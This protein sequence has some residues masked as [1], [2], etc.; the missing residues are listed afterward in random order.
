MPSFNS[1][2]HNAEGHKAMVGLGKVVSPDR[3][4]SAASANTPV[5]PAPKRQTVSATEA[6]VLAQAKQQKKAVKNKKK[7]EKRKAANALLAQFKAGGVVQ[8]AAGVNI[9]VNPGAVPAVPVY[10]SGAQRQIMGPTNNNVITDTRFQ[11]THSPQPTSTPN[12]SAPQQPVWFNNFDVQY[13]QELLQTQTT[14]VVSNV[15]TFA[16]IQNLA[17]TPTQRAV[18]RNGE[19]DMK[20]REKVPS[21]AELILTYIF[22]MAALGLPVNGE[23]PVVNPR[24]H[25]KIKQTNNPHVITPLVLLDTGAQVTC[26]RDTIFQ[27]LRIPNTEL[28]PVTTQVAAANGSLL[29][30]LGVIMLDIECFCY[31]ANCPGT[32]PISFHV[33]KGL[34]EQILLSN[35]H[36]QQLGLVTIRNDNEKLF[37]APQSEHPGSFKSLIN[38]LSLSWPEPGNLT[39]TKHTCPTQKDSDLDELN[40][41]A[42]EIESKSK[43]IKNV[44]DTIKKYCVRTSKSI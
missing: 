18:S 1:Q 19:C 2:F 29:E 26:I 22:T 28:K 24:K 30:V 40:G 11:E 3:K 32:K 17:S 10:A 33:I 16:S 31:K 8:T 5:V 37:V 41:I 39:K 36:C 38:N 44:P 20:V 43:H 9:P 42:S 35:R 15:K 14:R 23:T 25:M 13:V 12:V 34:A 27:Q 4:A 21:K 6:L 7:N